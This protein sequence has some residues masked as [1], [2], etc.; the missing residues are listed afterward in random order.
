MDSW[1]S[2][3]TD[4]W[5]SVSVWQVCRDFLVGKCN[6]TNCRYVHSTAADGKRRSGSSSDV[7]KDFLNGRCNRSV[8]RFYHP[9]SAANERATTQAV[10]DSSSDVCKDFLNGRCNRSVCR[11]YH[12]PST[13]DDRA[14]QAVSTGV[15]SALESTVSVVWNNVMWFN[16]L[17]GTVVNWLHFAIQVYMTYILL[18][19]GKAGAEYCDQY[20]CVSVCLSVC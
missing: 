20:V 14:T 8:C 15:S 6:R 3:V 1:M 5:W 16:A 12:P 18:R 4:L 2:V 17:K 13:A 11:F 9:P 10:S 7:C 19:P